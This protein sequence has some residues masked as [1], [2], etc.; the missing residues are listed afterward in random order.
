MKKRCVFVSKEL[1]NQEG[2]FYCALDAD[3]LNEQQHLE[4]GAFY[5]WKKTD[6]EKLLN[7]DFN[8]FSDVFNINDFGLWKDDNYVLIQTKSLKEIAV[9]NKIS[10]VKLESKEILGTIVVQ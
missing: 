10:L 1:S 8:L 4:E 9:Q 6:L 3:S 5:V 7:E 2:G